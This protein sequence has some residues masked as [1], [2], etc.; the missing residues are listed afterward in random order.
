MSTAGRSSNATGRSSAANVRSSAGAGK[1]VSAVSDSLPG[2]SRP[3]TDMT[4]GKSVS[5]LVDSLQRD[6]R[7]ADDMHMAS[8]D[9]AATDTASGHK[10]NLFPTTVRASGHGD[11]LSSTAEAVHAVSDQSGMSISAKDSSRSSSS[12]ADSHGMQAIKQ[13]SARALTRSSLDWGVVS[14]QQGKSPMAKAGK[15]HT[16]G[17]DSLIG[18]GKTGSMTSVGASSAK[19]SMRASRAS[20]TA[21]KEAHHMQ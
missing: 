15:Q 2:D 8:A 17:G 10:Q 7:M 1:A 6:S 13:S 4:A 14:E 12:A 3:A 9:V 16:L 18:M 20:L 21:G 5:A 11:L 19:A